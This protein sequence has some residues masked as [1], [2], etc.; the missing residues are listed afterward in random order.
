MSKRNLAI[1]F[2]V[3]FVA[4]VAIVGVAIGVGHPS[5]PSDDIAVV[6]DSSINVP[7]LVE[8]GHISVD[9]FNKI[10]LQTAKQAGLADIPN[11][12]DPQYKNVRDQAI[13]TAL[14]IAWITGEA[15]R[16]GV[17]VTD[18]QVQQQFAQTKAQNFK[19][20][21]DYQQFLQQQGLTQADVLLRVRLQALSTAIQDKLTNDVP[22]PSE[23]EAKDFYDANKDRLTTP[24]N[25]DIRIIQNKDA[26]KVNQALAA[27]K[28]DSS[29]ASWQK[30]ASQ[31]STDVNSNQQGGA[32]RDVVPGSFDQPLDDDIFKA[33]QGEIQG[34]ITTPTGTY[35][36]VV[37]AIH[38]ASTQ[39]FDSAKAT[40]IQQLKSTNQQAAFTAFLASYRDYW[41]SLTF[42][43]EDYL[44]SRC[45]NF[46]GNP[47]PPMSASAACK[48]AGLAL[49]FSMP[50]IMGSRGSSFKKPTITSSPTSGL[51]KKPRLIPCIQARYS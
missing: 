28:A 8:D 49:L 38:P 43:G 19:T 10:F 3:V 36:F 25:R 39:S 16:R 47:S 48:G 20:E 29:D 42:C 21:A 33:P 2:A 22:T 51:K 7:G 17:E 34:P 27:L 44:I 5:V 26:A 46:T 14:D 41:S 37:D 18:T 9:G 12:T 13:G 35:I 45:D 30:V 11:T 31:Y 1:A 40:I 6:D 15:Q 23:S 24:A 32:R 4:T 50:K